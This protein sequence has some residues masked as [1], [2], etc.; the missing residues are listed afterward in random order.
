MLAVRWQ[1]ESNL[2]ALLNRAEL[3]RLIE[4]TPSEDIAITTGDGNPHCLWS[5]VGSTWSSVMDNDL[6]IVRMLRK[7]SSF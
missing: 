2:L 3:R 5:L 6:K 1:E 4:G 7:E